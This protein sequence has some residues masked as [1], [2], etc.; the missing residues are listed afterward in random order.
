MADRHVPAGTDAW[1]AADRFV[2]KEPEQEPASS[3]AGYSKNQGF[4]RAPQTP[5]QQRQLQELLRR[6]QLEAEALRRRN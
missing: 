2:S 5:A 4:S 3:E 1:K 6:Q